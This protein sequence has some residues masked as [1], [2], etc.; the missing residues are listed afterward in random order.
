MT[1][2]TQPQS[3]SKNTISIEPQP[4]SITA[5]GG[6][7]MARMTWRQDIMQFDIYGVAVSNK[8]ND[9]TLSFINDSRFS[10]FV[11]MKV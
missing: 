8:I 4:R 6:K 1:P 5:K 3:V 11:S 2:G 7:M 10:K 9:Y